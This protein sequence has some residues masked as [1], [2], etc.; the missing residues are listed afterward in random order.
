MSR[1]IELKID[2]LEQDSSTSD[3]SKNFNEIEHITGNG[4]EKL[5][6]S[7]KSVGNSK[8]INLKY[9]SLLDPIHGSNQKLVPL[10]NSAYGSI[11]YSQ[12]PHL[13]LNK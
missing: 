3:R 9:D 6:L 2:K 4:K 1:E 5:D 11:L 8:L 13:L 10:R 7:K 12:L